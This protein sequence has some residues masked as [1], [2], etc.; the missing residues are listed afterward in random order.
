MPAMCKVFM[1]IVL[2]V[3]NYVRHSPQLQVFILKLQ[4]Q[5]T[6]KNYRTR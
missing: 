5:I 6:V 4:R 2:G 1:L 3:P